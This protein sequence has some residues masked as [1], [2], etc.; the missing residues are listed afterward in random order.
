MGLR[1]LGFAAGE[2]E[3]WRAADLGGV[4]RHQLMQRLEDIDVTIANAL[5]DGIREE[6]EAAQLES[7]VDLFQHSAPPLQLLEAVKRYG[8]KHFHRPDAI[9]PEEVASALYFASIAAALVRHGKR[10]T[11]SDDEVLQYGF[12][13]MLERPWIEAPLRELFERG[14][15]QTGATHNAA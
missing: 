11:T 6:V 2:N 15:G 13:R 5:K 4:L 10:I 1:V 12:E 8:R 3:L 14:L 9:L 7:L